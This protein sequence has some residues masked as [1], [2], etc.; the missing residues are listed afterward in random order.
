MKKL[1]SGIG[2]ELYFETDINFWALYQSKRSYL[3]VVQYSIN[4]NIYVAILIFH[5]EN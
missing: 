2:E 4:V 5:V 3:Y 1:N